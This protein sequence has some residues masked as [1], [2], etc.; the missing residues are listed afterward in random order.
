VSVGCAAP[1]GVGCAAPDGDAEGEP[2]GV[3]DG[4][5]EGEPL[6]VTDGELPGPAGDA[7][8]R[9]ARTMTTIAIEAN[10]A[11]PAGI[12]PPIA[13]RRGACSG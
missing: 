2:L 7:M 4:D 10:A 3:T 13:A 5:A 8:K 1:D 9:D 11:I 6:G 12:R